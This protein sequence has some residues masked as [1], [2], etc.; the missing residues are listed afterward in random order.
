MEEA[1]RL[2]KQGNERNPRDAAIL[3]VSSVLALLAALGMFSRACVRMWPV[4]P[5]AASYPKLACCLCN[6]RLWPI[7]MLCSLLPS[8]LIRAWSSLLLLPGLGATR[9]GGGQHR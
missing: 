7:V 8:Y 1:R 4:L 9:G 2:F 3:Q 5:K 6:V